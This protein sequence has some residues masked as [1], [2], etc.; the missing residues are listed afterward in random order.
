MQAD[1]RVEPLRVVGPVE[2]SAASWMS[3]AARHAF[4]RRAA[5][6]VAETQIASMESPARFDT[7][8]P[9]SFTGRKSAS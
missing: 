7:I 9:C 5:S 3:I 8:P 4:S 1:A 6:G 2:L